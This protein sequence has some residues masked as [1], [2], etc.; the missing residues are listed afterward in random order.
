MVSTVW[1]HSFYFSVSEP[2]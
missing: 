2:Y 1:Q